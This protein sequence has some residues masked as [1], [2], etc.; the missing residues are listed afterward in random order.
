M[1]DGPRKQ[2]RPVIFGS[3]PSARPRNAQ[4]HPAAVGRLD[5]D[6]RGRAPP[7]RGASSAA[8]SNP[9]V[10]APHQ[11]RQV[12]LDRHVQ[13]QYR[14]DVLAHG[15]P[16][17]CRPAAP[18]RVGPA[19]RRRSEHISPVQ[20]LVQLLQLAHHVRVAVDR[21]LGHARVDLNG[22][23]PRREHELVL[24]FT[25]EQRL[26]TH[27]PQGQRRKAAFPRPAPGAARRSPQH[28]GLNQQRQKRLHRVVPGGQAARRADPAE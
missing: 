26:D 17:R 23:A 28:H 22:R 7:P 27:L 21:P 16:T 25:R 24:H 10:Q 15:P 12:L 6:L 20:G 3:I 9:R 8:A 14:Q 11:L 2:V 18:L 4:L 1:Q 13:A 19:V 5:A